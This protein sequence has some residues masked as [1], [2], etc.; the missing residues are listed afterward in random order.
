MK[1]EENKIKRLKI[2]I[3]V[4]ALA[5]TF[6]TAVFCAYWGTQQLFMSNYEASIDKARYVD[7]M[8]EEKYLEWKRMKEIIK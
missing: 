4:M 5:I 2:L 6:E 7:E 8:V 1:S 3:F